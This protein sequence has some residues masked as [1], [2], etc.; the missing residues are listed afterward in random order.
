MTMICAPVLL[1]CLRRFAGITGV[2]VFNLGASVAVSRAV[3]RY[4]IRVERTFRSAFR[5]ALEVQAFSP[6][7][8]QWAESL[9]KKSGID[10]AL[11]RRSTRTSRIW[12]FGSVSHSR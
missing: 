2:Q 9:I 7:H 5:G 12:R 6:L 10:A 4:G 8:Q 11:K 1:R 3:L